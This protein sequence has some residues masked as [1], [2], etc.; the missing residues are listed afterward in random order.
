M[1]DAKQMIDSIEE[2]EEE[3]ENKFEGLETNVNWKASLS[4]DE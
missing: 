1:I 3:S 2:F 4:H